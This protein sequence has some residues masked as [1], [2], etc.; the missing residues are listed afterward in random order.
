MGQDLAT[1]NT[2]VTE[3]TTVAADFLKNLHDLDAIWK[4]IMVARERDAGF[5]GA[6]PLDE[7]INRGY[8]LPPCPDH[9][10][11]LAADG[12]QIYPDLH[13]ASLYWLINIGVFAY[14][15][16]T[17]ELPIPVTEPQ[18]FYSV[19]DVRD[20][21]GR[22]IANATINARR[23]VSEVKMLAREARN[24]LQRPQPRI[25]IYDGP[26]LG[27]VLGKEI[28]EKDAAALAHDYHES[29]E[30]LQDLDTLLCGYVDRP[31][32]RFVVLMLYLMS[33]DPSAIKRSALQTTG[34]L[35]G[36][37]DADIFKRLLRSGERSALMVQQSP[38]NKE[39]REKWGDDHEIVFF[40]LNVAAPHQEPYLARVEMPMSVAR[41]AGLVNAIHALLYDQCQL[42]DRYPYALTRADEIAVVSPHE[43]RALDDMIAVELLKN[44]QAVEISHKLSTKG[45]AR[46]PRQ[47]YPF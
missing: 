29:F 47:Q 44:R 31:S 38:Q 4:Q 45:M 10:T 20:K 14:F 13:G 9:G 26:L 37:T 19:A 40:Y 24:H 1:N 12:S 41:S 5:R 23:T 16:G 33:L 8:P 43:K 27:L 15:Q 32:S 22:P 11:I 36:V 46:A 28:T 39:Y 3:Q 42:T 18:L 25:A 7:A 21:E 6:G 17:D 34:S 30:I 2:S 35:E